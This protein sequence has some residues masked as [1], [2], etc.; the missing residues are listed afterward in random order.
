MS[1]LITGQEIE[2]TMIGSVKEAA[3][4]HTKLEAL[5]TIKKKVRKDAG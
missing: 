4:Y 1:K 5:P 2:N 3:G